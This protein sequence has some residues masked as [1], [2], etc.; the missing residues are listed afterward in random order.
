MSAPP[1]EDKD[2]IQLKKEKLELEAKVEALRKESYRLQLENDV[3]KKATELLKKDKGIS[4]EHLTNRDKAIVIDA[5]RDRYLLTDLLTILNM[6]KS[7]Y[8]YQESVLR[9][10]GA[11]WN[12]TFQFSYPNYF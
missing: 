3:L 10:G 8:C 1:N 12:L 11:D 7:S 6:A 5:L 9:K 4:L 2:V